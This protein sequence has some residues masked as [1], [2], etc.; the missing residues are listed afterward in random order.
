[1]KEEE[2]KSKPNP[3]TNEDWTRY[4]EKGKEIEGRESR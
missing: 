3:D 4:E 1:M 2:L